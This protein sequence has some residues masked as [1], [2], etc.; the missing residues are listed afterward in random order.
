MRVEHLCRKYHRRG[1]GNIA[2]VPGRSNLHKNSYD[3]MATQ[4]RTLRQKRSVQIYGLLLDGK[5][6]K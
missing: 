4:N 3:E 6:A 1:N 2:V 5:Y